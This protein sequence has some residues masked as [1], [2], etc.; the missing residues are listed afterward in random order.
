VGRPE[1]QAGIAD[2]FGLFF[3]ID[4]SVNIEYHPDL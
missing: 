1:T 4:R 3:L 2:S